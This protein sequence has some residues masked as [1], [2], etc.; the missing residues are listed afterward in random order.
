MAR[1]GGALNLREVAFAKLAPEQIVRH[2]V[3][4]PCGGRIVSSAFVP[5][6]C[7]IAA[8][9]ARYHVLDLFEKNGPEVL[10]ISIEYA[11]KQSLQ[12]EPTEQ[13]ELEHQL[14]KGIAPE[15][16]LGIE[17]SLK[18]KNIST[19]ENLSGAAKALLSEILKDDRSDTKGYRFARLGH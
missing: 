5:H 8:E 10:I 7:T 1:L 15:Q 6:K 11:F 14:S 4:R 3:D 17:R 13:R 12:A 19:L 18:N 16:A 2:C 9:L